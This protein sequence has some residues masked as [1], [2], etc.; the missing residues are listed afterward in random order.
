MGDL[1]Q[2]LGALLQRH[3]QGQG[4]PQHIQGIIYHKPAGNANPD[5]R[6]AVR[7]HR[8]EGDV[9]RRQDDVLR[10]QVRAGVDGV[11]IPA[12]GGVLQQPLRPGVIG[13][14]HAHI[15]VLEQDGLGVAVGLH[16][17]VEVQ[18]VL[19]Q[20]GKDAHGEADAIHPLQKQRVGGGLH[21]H[22]G[23]AGGAHPGEQLLKLQGL[24]RGALRGDHLVADH[25]LVGADE[26]HLGP[27]LLLQHGFQQVGGGGLAVGAGDGHHGHVVRGMAVVIGRHHRQGLAG[28]RHLDIGDAGVLRR[29]L[30]HHRR[31]AR[32][33]GLADIGVAVG[34]EAGHGHEHVPRRRGPGV[35]ADAGDLRLRIRRGGQGREPR[36]KFFQFHIVIRPFCAV[37]RAARRTSL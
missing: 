26:A 30:A 33:R 9:V 17:L 22:V 25:V 18:V 4:R 16:G 37:W 7:R 28:I 13:V 29:P 12:A 1:G 34:G 27:Q 14:V 31:G 21:H 20:V 35:V 11:G 15:A 19:G 36:Q 3:P 10:P 24:R 8:V 23:A 2:G 6:P 5:G 32:R